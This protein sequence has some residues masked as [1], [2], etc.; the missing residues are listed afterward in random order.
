VYQNCEGTPEER[1]I[2]AWNAQTHMAEIDNVEDKR[3][4]DL[5]TYDF[6]FGMEIIRRYFFQTWKI[7]NGIPNFFQQKFIYDTKVESLL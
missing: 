1:G 2:V 5:E 4:A 3:K 7:N 6:P